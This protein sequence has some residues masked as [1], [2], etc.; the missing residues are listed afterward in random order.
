MK[1][2]VAVEGPDP[3]DELRDLRE[4]IENDSDLRTHVA[5]SYAVADQGPDD[6]GPALD[7]L[8]FFVSSG[9]SL[10][11]LMVSIAAWCDSRRQQPT[12][13]FRRDGS[14]P[15]TLTMTASDEMTVREITVRL[16]EDADPSDSEA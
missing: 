16:S 3:A 2:S 12:L 4:W 13:K 9:I 5:V 15:R 7:L 14:H 6:M 10:G 8:E 11:S 1:F